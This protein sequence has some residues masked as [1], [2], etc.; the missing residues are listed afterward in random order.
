MWYKPY[1]GLSF[2]LLREYDDCFMTR[3]PEGF[4]NVVL[5]E[6]AVITED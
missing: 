5:K 4:A 3:E 6:D 2:P 1:V